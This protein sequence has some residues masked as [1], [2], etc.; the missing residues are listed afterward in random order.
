MRLELSMVVT[1]FLWQLVMIMPARIERDNGFLKSVIFQQES[2]IIIAV[3]SR[4]GGKTA[5]MK[6]WMGLLEIQQNRL[7]R[8][9][10][11]NF[12]TNFGMVC[13]FINLHFRVDHFELLIKKLQMTHNAQSVG[14]NRCLLRTAE[15]PLIY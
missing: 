3:K 10:I 11:S 15:M 13:A 14:Y 5:V 12:F 6:G 4:V 9:R 2:E 1:M 7:E 8:N